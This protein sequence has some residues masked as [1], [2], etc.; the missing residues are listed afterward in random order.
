MN[1]KSLKKVMD[2]AEGNA[3][4]DILVKNVN[5]VNVATKEIEKADVSISE[6]IIARVGL[7]KDNNSTYEAENI[8]DGEGKYLIP[9]L[10]D[11]HT[12]IEMCFLS[13]SAYADAVLQQGTTGAVLDMHDVCNVSIESMHYFAKEIATTPLKG[14]LMIP[15][16]VPAT[17]NLEDAGAE[18]DLEELKKAVKLPNIKG[19]G[20]TMD[21]NRVL[22]REKEIIS[23][24][25][26]AKEQGYRIDGHCP[27][28]RGD[29][30]QAYA[31]AGII[32]DH[33]SG[34]IEEML[35]KYRLG[36]KVILRR[37]SIEEPV[38]AGDFVNQLKDT[39]NVMLATDGCIYLDD[40]LNKGHMIHALR[41]I[42]SEGVD[43]VTAIQ[44]ATIN[45]ARTYGMEHEVGIIAPGRY[46]DMVLVDN[47]KDL[48]I[49]CVIANGQK[50]EIDKN[51]VYPEYDYPSSV[52]NSVT[53]DNITAQDLEIK[54]PIDEGEIIVKVI[55]VNDKEVVTKELHETVKVSQGKIV[56]DTSKDILKVAVIDRYHDQ[57]L[58]TVALVK[59]F[60]LKQGAFG[61]TIGQDSQNL[62]V[63]GANDNDMVRVIDAL[64]EIQGGVVVANNG[65]VVSKVWL[66]IAGIMSRL[67][68]WK[69]NSEFESLHK[70][71]KE[72]GCEMR[73]PSFALSLMI[74]CAVIPELKMT[75]RGLVD[76]NKGEFV[77]LFVD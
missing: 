63:V 54:A 49:L 71:L 46:A 9:G 30:L 66:P 58:K 34:N 11:A 70:T 24:L 56:A 73:N 38:K 13:P 77:S 18:M 44:M 61:G 23:M 50:I 55:G 1:Y 68:P 67:N 12:H 43:P 39:T 65:Q 3:K 76:A 60:G 59:G 22:E 2:V 8:I 62:I 35:E 75:N 74:T 14:Y 53:L 19:I 15:P 7:S 52:L 6:G 41:E 5:L 47:L 29:S 36:M 69:L 10:I 37:G 45:V 48:N 31:A 28:L 26:W 20:E 64:R 16:C 57:G 32:S 4:A 25:A 42:I 51:K 72:L 27:G 21:F 33:E 40:I 17:P